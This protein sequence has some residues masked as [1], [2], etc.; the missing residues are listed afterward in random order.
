MTDGIK[1][2]K[3]APYRKSYLIPLWVIQLGLSTFVA[4]FAGISIPVDNNNPDAQIRSNH[5]VQTAFDVVH[6]LLNLALIASII[7]IIIKFSNFT[8]TTRI[9]KIQSIAAV[10]MGAICIVLY[11]TQGGDDFILDVFPGTA[12]LASV[13]IFVRVYLLRRKVKRGELGEMK[14]GMDVEVRDV[15]ARPDVELQDGNK[16]RGMDG[17]RAGPNVKVVLGAGFEAAKPRPSFNSGISGGPEKAV[18]EFV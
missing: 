13:A 9:F 2:R 16:F 7:Y 17:G 3:H 14:R 6:L 5:S 1:V 4:I 18:R 12:W 11:C 10:V 15:E 8:L